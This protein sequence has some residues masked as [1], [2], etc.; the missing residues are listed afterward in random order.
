MEQ[1]MIDVYDFC[2]ACA[3]GTKVKIS[4]YTYEG[5]EFITSL[6]LSDAKTGFKALSAIVGYGFIESF[7][8][9]ADVLCCKVYV[10]R[11][12]L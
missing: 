12:D 1:K 8:A 7:Y 3:D 10:H 4:V 9:S 2:G 6:V 5:N 11:N